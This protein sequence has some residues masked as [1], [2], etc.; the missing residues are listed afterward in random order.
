MAEFFETKT[1]YEVTYVNF[2]RNN[3]P[4]EWNQYRDGELQAKTEDDLI[5]IYFH[6][7]AGDQ[8]MQ[9]KWYGFAR[10]LE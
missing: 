8:N 4:A 1:R 3:S 7:R 10:T 9:Y 6:G 2:T 5:I